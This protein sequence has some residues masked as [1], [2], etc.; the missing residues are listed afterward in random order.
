[1]DT[2]WTE[3]EAISFE[4]AKECI[5]HMIAIQSH[6]LAE[7]KSK[8]EPDASRIEE[9]RA[10]QARLAHERAD[11]KINDQASI[12][13]IRTE[14]GAAVRSWNQQLAKQHS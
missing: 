14:Y 8:P 13:R 2:S 4:C 12:T 10:E 7:E 11:L 9:L 6:L 1:M 5:S 3:M